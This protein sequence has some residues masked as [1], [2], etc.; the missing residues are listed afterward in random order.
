MKRIY[1]DNAASTPI[2]PE[3]LRSMIEANKNNYGNPLSIHEEGRRAKLS[4]EK[5]R[6]EIADLISC[7][8]DEIIFTNG[9]TEA[10]NLAIL[11]IAGEYGEKYKKP[12]I[13]SSAIE[14][15]SII[16][17]LE[18]LEKKGFK[19]EFV[20]VDKNGKI[21]L[22]Q[23]KKYI[24]K[25]T[26]LVSVMLANNEV[27][28]IQPMKEI[29]KIISKT[30]AMLH[31]DAANH[32]LDF[33]VKNL[34]I[35]L[36]TINGGKLGGPKGTGLL[37]VKKGIKISPII[38]GAKQERGM[39]AGTE[40]LPGIIGLSKAIE[41]NQKRLAGNV[42]KLREIRDYTIKNVLRAIPYSILTGDPKNRL[43]QIASFIIPGTEGESL[44]LMLDRR[45]VSVSTGSA[46]NSLSLK[47]SA[48]LLAMGFSQEIIHGSLRVSLGED[49]TKKQI[50]YF[51]SEL[52]KIV[53]RL[54]EISSFK[55]WKTK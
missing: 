27:G 25:Q 28:T 15:K 48:V 22:N 16:K 40:N 36:M 3:V 32:Y 30:H 29:S 35:D 19:I 53:I 10:N 33:N 12:K 20:G 47:P 18:Y 5:A 14:H 51:V 24:D 49:I 39:R 31:T 34:G 23:L 54:R 7:E 45:G 13:I 52:R 46:C 9:G 1:L 11:G 55:S 37:Y 6:S 4:L 17:P 44:V 8:K 38:F 26:I 50:D 41:I 2:L 43:P 21:N 42:K